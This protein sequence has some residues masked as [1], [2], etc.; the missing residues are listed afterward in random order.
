MPCE[1][2]GDIRGKVKGFGGVVPRVQRF[3]DELERLPT[4]RAASH[5]TVEELRDELAATMAERD[6]LQDEVARLKERVALDAE[7]QESLLAQLCGAA[8]RSAA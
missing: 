4:E 8:P 5:Q 2:R 1:R 3:H 7:V 6:A